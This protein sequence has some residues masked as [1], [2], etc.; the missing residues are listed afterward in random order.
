MKALLVLFI[1]LT[2][3]PVAKSQTCQQV[4]SPAAPQSL[5]WR[6][7]YDDAF[8]AF[9]SNAPHF[10]AWLRHQHSPLL[11]PRGIVSGDPHILNFGDVLM[12]S[13]QRKY[14][15][16]DVDDSGLQAPL[17]GDL[18]RY[19][20]SNQVSPF[21]VKTSDLIEA[22]R[23]GLSG[24][25]REKPELLKELESR[26]D[27]DNNK[28]QEKYIRKLT[29]NDSFGDK[30]NVTRLSDGTPEIQRFFKKV[31]V[32]L[33][34][35]ADGYEILD[36]GYR[37]K[38]TGGS[39]GLAR[40]WFLLRKDSKMHIW[41]F[42]EQGVPAT[43]EFLPQGPHQERVQKVIEA[44]RPSETYGP[45]EIVQSAG[46]SF[47]LRERTTTSL[48]FDPAKMKS[49]QDLRDGTELSVY[50]AYKLGRWHSE[51]MAAKELARMLNIEE[52]RHQLVELSEHYISLIEK[53]MAP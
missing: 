10:W 47:L 21:K 2:N 1:I 50:L 11:Q 41:E 8:M 25:H 53:E 28:A 27:K 5:P 34:Q 43:A 39:Q 51:Q 23:D 15:L 31:E 42:K 52:N 40:F 12:K 46:H 17:A 37:S 3:S 6:G 9:R 44:Y 24:L 18:I 14:T 36:V 49:E 45:Y 4:F 35:R 13:G 26:S 33:R 30:A 7:Q 48:D 16:V 22:Y 29:D 19:L 32:D 20:V 38:S